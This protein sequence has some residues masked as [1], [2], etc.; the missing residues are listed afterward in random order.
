MVSLILTHVEKIENSIHRAFKL[1]PS[2]DNIAIIYHLNV[3]SGNDCLSKIETIGVKNLT[4]GYSNTVLKN[5]NF[6]FE[7]GDVIKLEGI[8]GSGKSTLIKLLLQIYHPHE[9]II[10]V[11]NIDYRKFKLSSYLSK[12]VYVGQDEKLLNLKMIDYHKIVISNSFNENEYKEIC[13][14]LNL[15]FDKEILDNGLNLSQGQRKKVLLI[16]LLL[17]NN[18][19]ELIILDEAFAGLDIETKKYLFEFINDLSKDKILLVINHEIDDIKYTKTIKLGKL[20]EE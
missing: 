15:D 10:L 16:K 8:N 1:K 18:E 14:N 9:G 19:K 11:N 5:V 20:I 4:F 7:K 17:M 2:I 12:V 3:F 6:E 13:K